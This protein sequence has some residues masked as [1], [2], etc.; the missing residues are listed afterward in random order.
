MYGNYILKY[1][2]NICINEEIASDKLREMQNV[3]E[4]GYK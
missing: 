4:K 3:Q 1:V 2:V